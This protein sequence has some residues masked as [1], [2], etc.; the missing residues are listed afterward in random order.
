V[1]RAAILTLAF[2]A[3]SPAWVESVEFPWNAYPR[4]LWER[5]LAWLKN[6]GVGHVSLPPAADSDA[7]RARLAEAIQIVRRLDLEADL[8]GPVPDSMMPLM[9]AHGGPL[10]EAMAGDTVR[11]SVLDKSALT[12]SRDVLAS[13]ASGLIWTDVEDQLTSDGYHAGGVSF[14]GQERAATNALRRDALLSM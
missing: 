3:V 7:D 5:E 9:R 1:I 4:Q 10:T 12:R 13:G 11:L 2:A 14:A 6:I 8:E